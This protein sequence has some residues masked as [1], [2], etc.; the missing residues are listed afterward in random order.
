[1][2]FVKLRE[3]VGTVT[4]KGVSWGRDRLGR[5]EPGFLNANIIA[6]PHLPA[7]R[8]VSHRHQQLLFR[9]EAGHL[10]PFVRGLSR[11]ENPLAVSACSGL[12]CGLFVCLPAILPA[13][14][15]AYLIICPRSSLLCPVHFILLHFAFPCS[16]MCARIVVLGPAVCKLRELSRWQL[17]HGP[18][19]AAHAP[20]HLTFPFSCRVHDPGP[21]V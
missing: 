8:E 6:L 17:Q 4:G 20:V 14:P 18:A 5:S 21:W 10:W 16:S 7:R 13:M 3:W 11:A 19:V 2:G 1:M 15:T 12:F 9:C